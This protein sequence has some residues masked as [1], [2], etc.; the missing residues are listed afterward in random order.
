LQNIGLLIAAFDFGSTPPLDGGGI[1]SVGMQYGAG[2]K[3]RIHPR[4]TLSVDFRETWSK[5]PQFLSNSYTNSYFGGVGYQVTNNR[6][7]LNEPY[8][9]QRLSAGFAFTF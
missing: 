9:Q 6:L 7:G 1:F 2:M 3:Y 5:N 4:M 8:Q